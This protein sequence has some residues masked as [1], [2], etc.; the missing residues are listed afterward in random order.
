[1][2]IKLFLLMVFT[3]F[4]FACERKEAVSP[5]IDNAIIIASRQ[6]IFSYIKDNVDD[7]EYVYF[8]KKLW[9]YYI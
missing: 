8:E 9:N 6:Y 4:L 7:Y 5:I 3:M 1:M 2:R